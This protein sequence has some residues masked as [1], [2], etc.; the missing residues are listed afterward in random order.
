M[1][2]KSYMNTESKNNLKITTIIII[3]NKKE[4]IAN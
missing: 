4:M 3:S 2:N 1:K